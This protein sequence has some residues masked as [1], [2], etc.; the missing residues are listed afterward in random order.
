MVGVERLPAAFPFRRPCG[1]GRRRL[2]G[3][4]ERF[5]EIMTKASTV[6]A[7]AWPAGLDAAARLASS[8][9]EGLRILLGVVL[10]LMVLV[11]VANALGRYTA[12][13][14]LVGADEL[15]VYSMIWVVM[16]GMVIV[17]AER[18]HLALDVLPGRMA[19]ASKAAV[20]LL[21][22]AV[23]AAACGYAAWQSYAFVVRVARVG[24]VSMA[25]GIPM[26]IPHAALL[27]GFSLTAA[28]AAALCLRDLAE[29]AGT[30]S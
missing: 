13:I 16:T 30:R 8:F 5:G 7:R 6:P 29:I 27:A 23:M 24:Q 4:E 17:A 3:Q 1:P 21:C 28:V 12:G 11:N 18:R 14:A 19:G 20:A 10:V 25:L 9:V 15:I 26:T 2:A 22:D